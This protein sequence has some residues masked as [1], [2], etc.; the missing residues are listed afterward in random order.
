M[1]GGIVAQHIIQINKDLCSI[2]WLL[3]PWVCLVMSYHITLEENVCHARNKS[4][5]KRTHGAFNTQLVKWRCAVNI[6]LICSPLVSLTM[7]ECVTTVKHY[8][9]II[10]GRAWHEI[11]QVRPTQYIVQGRR[12]RAEGDM[13][14]LRLSNHEK[15]RSSQRKCREHLS[16]LPSHRDNVTHQ[17]I[18]IS[19][20]CYGEWCMEWPYPE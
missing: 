4:K 20:P 18:F 3:T 16:N 1:T 11:C 12:P 14:W 9:V 7:P 19:Q 5:V 13:S 6:I 15:Q 10:W 17:G 2:I 8:L